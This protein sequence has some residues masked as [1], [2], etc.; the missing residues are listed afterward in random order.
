M[1]LYTVLVALGYGVWLATR[2]ASGATRQA[3]R[4]HAP[5]IVGIGAM[6]TAS[7]LLILLALRTGVTSY[8]L[9]MRQVSI[10]VGGVDGMGG[11]LRERDVGSTPGRG[12][13]H[14]GRASR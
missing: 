1:Y 8:V 5:S 12:R 7:Y 14:R 3:W 2:V 11:A 4:A 9:G 6:N 13:P 10:A